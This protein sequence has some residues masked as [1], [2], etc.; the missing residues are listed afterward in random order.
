MVVVYINDGS[1]SNLWF[2]NVNCNFINWIEPSR[3]KGDDYDQPS[4]VMQFFSCIS[5]L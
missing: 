3:E 1:M 2:M 5:Q 4:K